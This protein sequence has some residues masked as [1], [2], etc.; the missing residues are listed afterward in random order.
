MQRLSPEDLQAIV[1]GVATNPELIAG[2]AAQ[3]RQTGTSGQQQS[4]QQNTSTTLPP[5]HSQGAQ[6]ETPTRSQQ[7]TETTSIQESHQ[8]GTQARPQGA[9]PSSQQLHSNPQELPLPTQGWLSVF[10]GC[11]ICR[12]HCTYMVRRY[13]PQT[14]HQV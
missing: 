13:P 14:P 12:A 6:Q 8:L 2:I 5:A 7:Q 4:Y 11:C 10:T 3:L 1:T 9:G